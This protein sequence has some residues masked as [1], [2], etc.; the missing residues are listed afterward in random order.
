MVWRAL[1]VPIGRRVFDDGLAITE[2][3]LVSI[4]DEVTFNMGSTLQSHTLEDGAFKSDHI[5]VGN[6]CT[7]GTGAFVNYG[8]DLGDGAILEADSFLMK[9]SRVPAGARWRGNPAA[10]VPEAPAAA[11]PLAADRAPEER[12]AS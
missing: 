7:I 9:G 8:A 11:L 12:Q 6:G 2:R 10:D 4:G 5:T 3:T 1:G